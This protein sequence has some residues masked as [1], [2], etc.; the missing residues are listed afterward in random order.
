MKRWAIGIQYFIPIG[1][2]LLMN[3]LFIM[4]YSQETRFPSGKIPQNWLKEIE[5]AVVGEGSE[6]GLVNRLNALEERMTGKIRG[7]SLEER[8]A[9]ID[10]QLYTNQPYNI[11][12]LYKIQALDW[13]LR[14]SQSEG[15]IQ[16]RLENLEK[17]VFGAVYSGP[18]TTRV[19]R[20]ISQ[21]FPGGVIKARW[22]NIPSG[23]LVKVRIL[24]DLNS[25]KNKPGD[26][27]RL[28]VADT[29]FEHRSI[30]FPRGTI[31]YGVL[32]EITHP[33]NLGRDAQL[34]I[35]FGEIRAMDATPIRLIYGSKALKMARS[36]QLAFGASAAGMLALGPGGIILGLAIKGKETA[37]PAGTEFYLEVVESAR[38]YTLNE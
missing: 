13:N 3:G 6:D 36:R 4:A 12:L 11:C 15:P 23:L 24:D 28:M 7:G 16:T 34:R 35:D 32:G 1:L 25:V 27:F 9:H 2:F 8:L 29:V 30:L 20:L 10:G 22:T 38:I 14:K 17:E 31:G 5:V 18:I 19:E 21:V 33:D 37:I 26:R